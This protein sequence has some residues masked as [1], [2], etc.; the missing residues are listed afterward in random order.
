[1]RIKTADPVSSQRIEKPWDTTRCYRHIL[2]NSGGTAEPSCMLSREHYRI[3]GEPRNRPA[4]RGVSITEP[5][6]NVG[7][8]LRAPPLT[9][10]NPEGSGTP[11]FSRIRPAQTHA[12]KKH[13][14]QK[15]P[16]CG[17][18]R[19]AAAPRGSAR[20]QPSN[21][22]RRGCETPGNPKSIGFPWI[23]D[24]QISRCESRSLAAYQDKIKPGR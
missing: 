24:T 9:P 5:S 20:A 15:I 18:G 8:H 10:P 3:P 6:G 17:L 12:S 19:E 21:P 13:E 7:S 2:E 16:G 23:S 11:G 14:S 4:G 22:A 1:M